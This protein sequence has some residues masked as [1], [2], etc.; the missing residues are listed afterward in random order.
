MNLMYTLPKS[1]YKTKESLLTISPYYHCL[2]LKTITI[3]SIVRELQAINI[4]Q[5]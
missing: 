1:Q 3:F 4:E 2:L 5:V